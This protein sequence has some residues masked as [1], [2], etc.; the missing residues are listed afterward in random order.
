MITI[1]SLTSERD[2]ALK[3]FSRAEFT[4]DSY[5]TRLDNA[6][7]KIEEMQK[8]IVSQG[9]INLCPVFSLTAL[10]DCDR[11]VLV[12]IDGDNTLVQCPPPGTEGKPIPSQR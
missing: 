12:L 11:F 2:E 6:E 10:Q 8:A 1:Q 7:R 5:Q 4:C 3:K 9:I